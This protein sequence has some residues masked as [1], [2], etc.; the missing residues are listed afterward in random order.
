MSF[1]S[2]IRNAI[3]GTDG[4]LSKSELFSAVCLIL[5]IYFSVG[6]GLKV[7]NNLAVDANVVNYLYA[8]GV[9]I[10]SNKGIDAWKEHL[11]K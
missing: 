2:Q 10:L 7:W 11:K 6:E 5:F 3:L 9:G 8:F 4:K 1:F